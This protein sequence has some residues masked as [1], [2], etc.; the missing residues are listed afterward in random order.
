MAGP[1]DEG[2]DPATSNVCAGELAGTDGNAYGSFKSRTASPLGDVGEGAH[3]RG[4]LPRTEG[5]AVA[6]TADDA[7]GRGGARPQA[8][9]HDH[10]ADERAPSCIAVA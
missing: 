1:F 6:I 10:N 7:P 4:E 2:P 9:V 8:A 5:E 3:R